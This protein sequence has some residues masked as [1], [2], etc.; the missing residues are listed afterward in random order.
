MEEDKEKKG[1]KPE[2]E[3]EKKPETEETKSQQTATGLEKG[4]EQRNKEL[5]EEKAQEIKKG[6]N[7]QG[8]LWIEP[9]DELKDALD[10][11]VKSFEKVEEER[12]KKA[13]LPPKPSEEELKLKLEIIDLKHR[14][15]DLEMELEKKAKEIKQNY[16]Q[17]MMI[18]R[19]FD[20]YKAR[21]MKEKADWFNYGYEPVLKELLLVMDNLERA[22]KHTE[23][24]Q[25][26]DALKQGIE[27]THRQFLNILEKFGVKQIKA[28]GEAF[29]PNYH[30]AMNQVLTD[31]HPPGIVLE[32]Y[33][34]G[35]I[36]KDRLL[37]PSRV[38]ISA[39]PEK[40]KNLEGQK[41]KDEDKE[42]SSP[43]SNNED[44]GG[45]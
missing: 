19:Q 9:S 4:S 25:N 20:D 41:A 37:R 31:Q 11:A 16:E 36:F 43:D 2:S 18:K 23:E 3:A 39:L 14:M 8:E 38:M 32:E 29:D 27:L 12:K 28:V 35:Y 6:I 26:F 34:K 15:R 33:G 21:M 45:E 42:K 1:L 44:K 13:E 40:D 24:G 5:A 22:I 17:A 30:E 10:E 7:E